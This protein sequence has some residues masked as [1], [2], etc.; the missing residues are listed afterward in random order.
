MKEA[1]FSVVAKVSSLMLEGSQEAQKG[2]GGWLLKYVPAKG[3]TPS[4][5]LTYLQFTSHKN[6]QTTS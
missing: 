3:L 2:A 5:I 1:W 6:K 4:L